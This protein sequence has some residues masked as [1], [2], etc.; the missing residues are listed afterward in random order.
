MLQDLVTDTAPYP[1]DIDGITRY[2][3]LR[4]QSSYHTRTM[5]IYNRLIT[6]PFPTA[7]EL[8]ALDDEH[9]SPWLAQI[10][11][12]YHDL[13]PAD[14]LFAL[15]IGITKWRYRN[16]RIVMYRPFLVRWALNAAPYERHSAA[17]PELLVIS[18]CLDAAQET[19]YAVEAY[20]MSRSHSRLA[21][22]Y[23]LYVDPLSSLFPP[24]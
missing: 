20:W 6:P 4:V 13:P 8:I 21:A 16:L 9:I 22:W 15:G 17:S 3:Y 2:T 18:K 1:P 12:Y 7:T 19:I 24:S 23:V 10:P 14:S 11:P 5:C